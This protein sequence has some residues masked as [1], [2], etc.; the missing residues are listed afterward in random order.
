MKNDPFI[1]TAFLKK[2]EQEQWSADGTNPLVT[3]SRQMGAEGE[4]IALRASEILTETS[5]DQHPWIVVDKDIAERVMEDHH[6]PGLIKRFFTEEQTLSI[7][8]HLEGLL[9]IST[10]A[11][12]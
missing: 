4:A 6:L 12:R 2:M 9:G 8:E 3:I 11:R 7:E 5:P 10:P 1:I